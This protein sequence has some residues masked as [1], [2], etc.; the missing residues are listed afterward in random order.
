M[1]LNRYYHFRPVLAACL[2][3]LG[4]LAHAEDGVVTATISVAKAEVASM[5]ESV[6]AFGTVEVPMARMHA[7]SVAYQAMLERVLVVPGQSVHKRDAL[8]VLHRTAASEL[9][10]S[11]AQNDANFS[12]KDVVRLKNLLAQHLATNAELALAEQTRQNAAAALKSAQRR[13]GADATRTLRAETDGLVAA[14]AVGPGDVVNADTLLLKIAEGSDLHVRLAIEPTALARIAKD[15]PVEITPLQSGAETSAG[16][17]DHVMRQIDAQ[18]RLA[19]AWIRLDDSSVLIPGSAVRARIQTATRTA[20]SVPRSA[21][22][23]E[24]EGAH[25]FVIVADKA[26][27]R[28][29]KLGIDD[30]QRIEILDGLK[31]GEVI[32]ISGNY[33]LEDGMRVRI[34]DNKP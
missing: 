29:V 4:T 27:E 16:K 22:L 21:V 19:A 10:I 9:E 17:V 34:E 6:S 12:E 5:H 11:R 13:L 8:L 30:G 25:V 31:P 24:G 20:L 15:Q 33:E 2:L 26:Q 3:L 14:V 23:P 7:Y 32:A 28:E 18:T 1:E